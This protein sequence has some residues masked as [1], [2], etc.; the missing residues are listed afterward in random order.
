MI[1]RIEND[2][3]D[4]IDSR[5]SWLGKFFA[6]LPETSMVTFALETRRSQ[7]RGLTFAVQLKSICTCSI[8]LATHGPHVFT[9]PFVLSGRVSIARC[10]WFR[11]QYFVTFWAIHALWPK[12]SRLALAFPFSSAF[13]A[14][15]LLP[16]SF[17]TARTPSGKTK[18]NYV[19]IWRSIAATQI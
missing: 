16:A 2:S 19:E 13:N 4:T 12:V 1:T 5:Q 17:H 14:L 7:L 6:I 15:A 11:E 3:I 10:R 18:V 8:I 9:Y